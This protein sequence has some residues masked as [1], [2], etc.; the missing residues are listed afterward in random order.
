V[1]A[2]PLNAIKR[3]RSKAFFY[4]RQCCPKGFRGLA[5]A[6]FYQIANGFS[7]SVAPIAVIISPKMCQLPDKLMF[8]G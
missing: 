7:T 5:Q 3:A 4:A 2:C 8:M 1:A 6:L